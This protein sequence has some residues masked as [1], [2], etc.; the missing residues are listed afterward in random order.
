MH[1]ESDIFCL[2]DVKEGENDGSQ[3]FSINGSMSR[4]ITRRDHNKQA[5]AFQ[6]GSVAPEVRPTAVEAGEPAPVLETVDLAESP[7]Q[8]EPVPFPDD[9]P[10]DVYDKFVAEMREELGEEVVDEILEKKR[11]EKFAQMERLAQEELAAREEVAAQKKL[12]AQ[13]ESKGAKPKDRTVFVKLKPEERV[14][15]SSIT[16]NPLTGAGMEYEE[17]KKH[18]KSACGKAERPLY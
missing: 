2:R 15:V 4:R 18:K 9:M 10:K 3:I 1:N 13:D 11:Q 14:S 17:P 7:E 12:A 8:P 5:S 16:R 6:Y